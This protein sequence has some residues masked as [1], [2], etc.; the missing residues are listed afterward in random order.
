MRGWEE[1][2]GKRLAS[3]NEMGFGFYL[4]GILRMSWSNKPTPGLYWFYEAGV[5]YTTVEVT[6]EVPEVTEEGTGLLEYW[7]IGMDNSYLVEGDTYF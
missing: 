1:N 7:M 5:G 4:W 2:N 3:I 6:Y